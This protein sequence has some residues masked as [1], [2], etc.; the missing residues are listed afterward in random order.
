MNYLEYFIPK[1]KD[2]DPIVPKWL[3]G[4][5]VGEPIDAA[6]NASMG[7]VA[8]SKNGITQDDYT[9]EK[10]QN[11]RDA[12]YE[13]GI[14]GI[15]E[16]ILPGWQVAKQVM[17]RTTGMLV[18]VGNKIVVKPLNQIA[19]KVKN[20]ISK[21]RQ[22]KLATAEEI[23]QA[24]LARA[25]Q[26]GFD[27]E[28]SNI[29]TGDL[30]DPVYRE[31]VTQ[32]I[33]SQASTSVV[34]TSEYL[35]DIK[36]LN[37]ELKNIGETLPGMG[38]SDYKVVHVN[39]NT[40]YF[41]LYKNNPTLTK[42]HEVE[43]AVHIPETAPPANSIDFKNLIEKC[44]EMRSPNYFVNKNSTEVGARISQVWNALGKSDAVPVTGKQLKSQFET[45]LRLGGDNNEISLLYQC[46]KDWDELAKWANN[47]RNV[48]TIG[49]IGSGVLFNTNNE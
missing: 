28:T 47:P 49:A 30:S 39:P 31:A 10:Y 17:P 36:I 4:L 43:H 19:N 40:E 14:Y 24:Y 22:Q 6:I 21:V 18:R 34:G 25:K 27:Y 35:E 13:S 44:R 37:A 20:S 16:F 48:Y 2:G 7:R 5:A 12:L 38:W 42:W 9:K 11:L 23:E 1:H 46:V 41:T 45:Y 29:L 26:K 15:T 32:R 8:D 33:A 3:S